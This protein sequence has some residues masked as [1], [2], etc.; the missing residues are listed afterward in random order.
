[1]D[2]YDMWREGHPDQQDWDKAFGEA[3]EKAKKLL[4]DG[5]T[6]IFD[7]GN[8][9]FMERENLRRLARGLGYKSIL[10][11][12]DTPIETIWER[13]K[14]NQLNKTRGHVKEERFQMALKMWERP[15]ERENP[16]I[17]TNGT[18]IKTLNV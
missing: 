18:D 6:V 17:F 15:G 5:K 13:R 4:L 9:V 2:G 14:Q 3:Y 12:M 11:F 16:I 8:L 1:M 7:S 10:V